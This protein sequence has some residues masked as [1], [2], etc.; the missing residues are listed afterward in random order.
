M[1]KLL[2]TTLTGS[3]YLAVI[4]SMSCGDKDKSPNPAV[5]CGKNAEKVTAAG[6]EWA[7]DVTNEASCLAY[8]AAVKEF[9]KSC[10]TYYNGAAKKALDD[11]LATPCK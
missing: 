4:L 6:T 1:Q 3:A 8:K 5:D 2:K 11:F 9:Y 10:E 7:K